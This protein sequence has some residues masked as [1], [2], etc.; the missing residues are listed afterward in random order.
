M[1][2]VP[3]CA[4]SNGSWPNVRCCNT[5]ATLMPGWWKRH[6]VGFYCFVASIPWRIASACA[7]IMLDWMVDEMKDNACS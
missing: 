1:P 2:H 5:R 4:M 7:R 6:D 3:R